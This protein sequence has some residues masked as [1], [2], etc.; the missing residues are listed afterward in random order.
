MTS[1]TILIVGGGPVGLT[2]A[3]ELYRH[4]VPCR[5]VELER[6][7]HEQSRATDIQAGTLRVLEDMGILDAFLEAGAVRDEFAMFADGELITQMNMRELD[8]PYPFALGLGQSE[9]ERLL[10]EHLQRLGGKLE[11]GVRVVSVSQQE[12]GVDVLFEGDRGTQTEHFDWVVGCDGSHSAVRKSVG[13]ALEGTTMAERFFLADVDFISDRSEREI[14]I[15]TGAHGA[16]IVLPIPGTVRVFGDLSEA[17]TEEVDLTFVRDELRKRTHGLA[18]ASALGWAATFNVHARI[19]ESYRKDRVFLAG[20]AAHIHSPAGGHGMNT[21]VQ[22]AYN[23]GWKLAL[24]AQGQAG[25]TLLDSYDA[26]RRPVGRAVVSE[27]DWETRAATWRSGFGQLAVGRLLGLA[28]KLPSLR[29]AMMIHALELDVAYPNS[30]IVGERRCWPLAPYIPGAGETEEPCISQWRAF[31]AGPA[32]GDA[33]PDVLFGEH[34]MF[35]LLR[36]T[37]Y[38][39]LLFD[40]HAATEEGYQRLNAAAAVLGAGPNKIPVHV[41]VPSSEVPSS[42]DA[43]SVLLDP[44][45]AAHDK[46]GADAECGYLIRPDGHI[47]FRTQP[48]DA[49]AMS[50]HLEQ[51]FISP[52]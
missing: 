22:D 47:G 30:P 33:A 23:L 17:Q 18:D 40:G 13:L 11:R 29:Q 32:P 36:G 49:L 27:T 46:F 31:A 6:Q 28:M 38:T 37:G 43:V 1:D 7:R 51:L 21:G 15:W 42:L 8:T 44:A 2:L 45:G 4:G 24:V 19:V 26:E 5:V 20:D 39:A 3:C 50:M 52:G 14:S 16:L 48:V 41:I 12:G 9:S 35:H 25:D 34:R 10:E